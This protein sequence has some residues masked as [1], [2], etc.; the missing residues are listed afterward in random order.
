M[1]LKA[2]DLDAFDAVLAKNGGNLRATIEQIIEAARKSDGKPF[3]ALKVLR[4]GERVS[5]TA[6]QSVSR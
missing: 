6:G 4:H 3:D 5:R 1:R 2:P